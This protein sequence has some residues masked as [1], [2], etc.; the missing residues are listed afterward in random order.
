MIIIAYLFSYG[1]L[2]WWAYQ[3]SAIGAEITLAHSLWVCTPLL[4][5]SLYNIYKATR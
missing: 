4:L 1:W 2:F 5:T 3:F